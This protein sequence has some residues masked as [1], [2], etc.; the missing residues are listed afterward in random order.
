MSRRVGDRKGQSLVE[1]ALILAAFMGL[2]LGMTSVGQL[3]FVRQTLSDRVHQAA[4]WGA[5]NSY[6]PIAIRDI[7]RFGT[8][9]PEP[10]QSPFLGLTQDAIDVSNPGCP[11]PQCRV[12]VVIPEH[13]IRSVEP[14]ES[15]I[16]D[17]AS[18][19]ATGAPSKP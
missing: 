8:S 11:G 12:R 15:G 7:V 17:T 13:G 16:T 18:A 10:G 1:T 19:P 14:M 9:A 2:L 4:R 6:N 3:V 5:V